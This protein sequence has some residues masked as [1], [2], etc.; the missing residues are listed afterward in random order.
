M[1]VFVRITDLVYVLTSVKHINKI[2]KYVTNY[3]YL[4][5]LTSIKMRFTKNV[6]K[7]SVLFC[8]NFNATTLCSIEYYKMKI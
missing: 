7:L 1:E 6:V 2:N 4:Y 8:Y 3:Q 5:K